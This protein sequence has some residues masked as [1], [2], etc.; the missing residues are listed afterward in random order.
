MSINPE[1]SINAYRLPGDFHKAP[2]DR[3]IVATA[4]TYDVSLLTV[5]KKILAYPYVK[6]IES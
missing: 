6:K 1:I 5:D 4:R 3:L 2:A